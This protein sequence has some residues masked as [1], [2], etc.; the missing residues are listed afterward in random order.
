MRRARDMRA[1]SRHLNVAIALARVAPLAIVLFMQMTWFWNVASHPSALRRDWW[2]FYET[3]RRLVA[4][5]FDA[6][7]PRTFETRALWLYPPFSIY[8]TATLGLL[9][10]HGAY[11]FC[12]LTELG[13]VIVGLALLRAALP[14]PRD[15]H[16]TAAAVVFAS[17]GFNTTLAVG[18]ISGILMMIL[19]AALSL[20]VRRRTFVGGLIAS[21]LFIKPNLAAFIGVAAVLAGEWTFIAGMMAGF[22]TLV[23]SSLP[24]GLARWSEYFFTSRHYVDLVTDAT[25]PL[26]QLTLYAFWH[27]LPGLSAPA[28]SALWAVTG[29]TLAALAGAAVYRTSRTSNDAARVLSLTVLVALAANF[30]AFFYDGLLLAVPG[31]VFYVRRRGYPSMRRIAIGACI[32]AVFVSGYVQVFVVSS[33]ISSVGMFIALWAALEAHDQLAQA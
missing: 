13:A 4:G 10:E 24:L 19:A 1:R 21:A 6:I 12:F 29:I 22:M 33:G 2:V 23:A 9:S 32:C 14:A 25:P 15:V 18:Q 8:L 26:N 31:I 16:W 20:W 27:S 28:A 5:Q 30:Y 7:Y 11:A 3:G 17:P